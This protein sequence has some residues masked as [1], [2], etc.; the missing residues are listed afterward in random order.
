V[1]SKK[2]KPRSCESAGT[3]AGHG[4]DWIHEAA[5]S[6]EARWLTETI[7]ATLHDLAAELGVSAERVRQ[8]EVKALA[9]M[10]A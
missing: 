4:V 10:R 9:K 3:R 7:P 1:S 8:I 5:A 2:R 6:V